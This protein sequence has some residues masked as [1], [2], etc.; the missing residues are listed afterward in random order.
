MIYIA[1][2][3]QMWFILEESLDPKR[4]EG[5]WSYDHKMFE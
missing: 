2:I 5:S 3:H 1:A 4:S